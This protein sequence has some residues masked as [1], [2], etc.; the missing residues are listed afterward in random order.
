MNIRSVLIGLAS[1]AL[2][3]LPSSAANLLDGFSGRTWFVDAH[4]GSGGDGSEER[5]YATIAAAVEAASSGDAIILAEGEYSE[6]NAIT[7]LGRTN[8]YV[9]KKLH[10]KGA[11]RGK[12][13]V[14]GS[15]DSSDAD[16]IG[17]QSVRCLTI[18]EGA[19]GCVFED[20]EFA[21]GSAESNFGGVF[22]KS[23]NAYFV[24]CTFRNCRARAGAGVAGGASEAFI[25]CLFD[26]NV[27]FGADAGAVLAGNI[28]GC[29]NCV[30]MRNALTTVS[31]TV[32]GANTPHPFVNCTFVGNSTGAIPSSGNAN[33]G[34]YYNC[35]F[36]NNNKAL[37]RGG[38]PVFY[39]LTDA[40][41][42]VNGG[43]HNFNTVND[44][45]ECRANAAYVIYS[46]LS[47]DFRPLQG[48]ALVGNGNV[49]YLTSQ[50]AWVPADCLGADYEG[51]ARVTGGTVCIGAIESPAVDSGCAPMLVNSDLKVNGVCSGAD[52]T[53]RKLWFR[54][55][56]WPCMVRLEYDESAD[57]ELFDFVTPHGVALMPDVEGGVWIVPEK[58]DTI[59]IDWSKT[60]GV[61]GVKSVKVNLAEGGVKWCDPKL[62]EGGYAEANGSFEH[63]YE[64]LQEAVTAVG[65]KG[66]VKA[67]S[68]TYAKGGA[69]AHYKGKARVVCTTKSIRIVGVEGAE[70]TIVI[71]AVNSEDEKTGDNAVR[72]FDCAYESGAIGIC[73]F[74]ITGCA[75]P[76]AASAAMTSSWGGGAV[77][78][79]HQQKVINI[80]T[81]ISDCIISNNWGYVAPA[82]YSGWAQ[83]CIITD[84]H[85]EV[86]QGVSA[87]RGASCIVS[88]LS[89]CLV[90]DNVKDGY[91]ASI[92][93]GSVVVNCT[94]R[95][96]SD[97]IRSVDD[98]T[99]V[100][101]NNIFS[102]CAT[103]SGASQSHMRGNICWKDAST[104]KNYAL[105]VDPLLANVGTGDYRVMSISRALDAGDATDTDYFIPYTVGQI[106]GRSTISDAGDVFVGACGSVACCVSGDDVSPAGTNAVD[107]AGQIVFRPSRDRP[108]EGYKVGTSEEL[109]PF[110]PG[111]TFVWTAA[112]P[113]A[114]VG[115]VLVVYGSNWYV[116]AESGVDDIDHG[117][118][119]LTPMKTLAGVFGRDVLAGDVIHA[120]E[121]NYDEGE[122]TNAV[123]FT[124]T[125][126]DGGRQM[127]SRVVVPSGVSLVADGER[128]NTVIWGR[129]HSETQRQGDN[130]L[131]GVFLN[132]NAVLDGFVVRN[133]ATT[134]I[135]GGDYSVNSGGC[136]AGPRALQATGTVRNCELWNG[137]ARR[138][139]GVY[140]CVVENCYIHDCTVSSDMC[141]SQY[142]KLI[143]TLIRNSSSTTVGN[144]C[145]IYNST[146]VSSSSVGVSEFQAWNNSP[147]VNSIVMIPQ[148][149]GQ[150]Q[151]AVKN[152]N[153]C[154]VNSA[155]TK[156][157]F[158]E[159][160]CANIDRKTLAEC[161]LD[162]ND[163][164]SPKVGSLAIDRGDASLLPEGIPAEDVRGGQRI[165]NREIDI[166]SAEFDWR[167][168]YKADLKQHNIAEV[169]EA[170][171]DVKENEN[172]NVE[173]V[174]GSR[175]VIKWPGA[176]QVFL[177]NF[178]IEGGGTLVVRENGKE[179]VEYTALS[180]NK[181]YKIQKAG[182][183]TELSFAYCGNGSATLLKFRRD[184]GLL[185]TVY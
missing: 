59:T 39:S 49:D 126:Y 67:K 46:P 150:P 75:S 42:T 152:W 143:N 10:V 41:G 132:E 102:E 108:V 123:D 142:S 85:Q 125:T 27:T 112:D 171:P 14:L 48:S 122:M 163:F 54:G 177:A 135:G 174:D 24:D 2:A 145:G 106:G 1:L 87:L 169:S 130:A 79:T 178:D 65:D 137:G 144:H 66:V 127:G 70:K 98:G 17:V 38:V 119:P 56:C 162:A 140:G 117:Y 33:S 80:T 8:M 179:A 133:G 156:F 45:V 116:N 44:G 74:T 147:V 110:G 63:P 32:I 40:Y 50:T 62:G 176:G 72:G 93:E 55:K 129:W 47:F 149:A 134:S 146:I 168:K 107:S 34:S 120:A 114:E 7:A 181:S 21:N 58:S 29:Y 22:G 111:R 173:L 97:S 15:H 77:V 11:G 118:D 52:S 104:F 9:D 88:V 184:S 60:D 103:G 154:I 109:L 172:S 166:G 164:Y 165:Y 175:V 23:D 96:V 185:L 37:T 89:S 183:D 31:G 151:L 157:E 148:N 141:A 20:I 53:D 153:N 68:G 3:S 18:A 158:D 136:V 139:A 155:N 64:T 12:T 61:T 101:L 100:R 13:L 92:G 81:Q 94:I 69:N 128:A 113:R 160:T 71:G 76:R 115:K 170:S 26:G 83:R 51:N 182:P 95:E 99:S 167:P 16:G 90:H 43:Y 4:A 73:G 131:R 19:A 30:F 159:G 5:P 86:P 121:G 180:A 84:N 25:R 6:V 36:L 124:G 57:G 91:I 138:G 78:A 28:A 161:N 35:L 82:I 105:V